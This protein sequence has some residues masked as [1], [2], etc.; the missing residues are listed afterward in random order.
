VR[1]KD[2]LVDR[3]SGVEL[4]W[5]PAAKKTHRP[6]IEGGLDN[7]ISTLETD[8]G[9]AA[10]RVSTTSTKRTSTQRSAGRLWINRPVP[11]ELG[12]TI[13][14]TKSLTDKSSIGYEQFTYPV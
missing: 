10:D 13:E 4:G 2:L 11:G 12:V 5:M 9:I 3:K 7:L 6:T 14:V 8:S 1:K